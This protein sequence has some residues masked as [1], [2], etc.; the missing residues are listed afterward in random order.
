MAVI[1]RYAT[2]FSVFFIAV[3]CDGLYDKDD[4]TS[5]EMAEAK[6]I[7]SVEHF[8]I[9]ILMYSARNKSIPL[10]IYQV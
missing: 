10:K 7:A 8:A 4:K 5:N 9:E 3:N 1:F 6:T 2:F